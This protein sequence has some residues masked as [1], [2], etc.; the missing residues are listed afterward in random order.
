MQPLMRAALLVLVFVPWGTELS[1]A[2]VTPPRSIFSNAL[3]LCRFACGLGPVAVT[4]L[5]VP[6]AERA[7]ATACAA[8]QPAAAFLC[9]R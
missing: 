4:I 5:P 9:R 8:V 7:A 3:N 1:L 2:Q 6:L